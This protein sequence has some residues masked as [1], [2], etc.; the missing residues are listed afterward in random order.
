MDVHPPFFL[1][2]VILFI[3]GGVRNQACPVVLIFSLEEI[4]QGN[5]ILDIVSLWNKR[6]GNKLNLFLVIFPL[7]FSEL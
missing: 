2:R 1:H 3:G 6:K 4:L 5:G 7:N